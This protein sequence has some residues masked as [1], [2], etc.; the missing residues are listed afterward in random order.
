MIYHDCDDEISTDAIEKLL[1][2]FSKSPD[3]DATLFDLKVEDREG[4]LHDFR[5]FS[6]DEILEGGDCFWESLNNWGVHS[7]VCLKKD[8]FIKANSLYDEYNL[9]H[10]NNISN[11][12]VIGRLCW[13]FCRKVAKTDAIYIYKNNLKSTTK[14]VNQNFYSVLL[15]DLILHKILTSK[16]LMRNSY[17]VYMINTMRL[18]VDKY[19]IWRSQLVERDL[20]R[21]QLKK[22]FWFISHYW[23]VLPLKW[24]RKFIKLFFRIYLL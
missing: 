23:R 13:L 24:K 5:Y 6:A 20:W 15:N 17:Y 1:L 21:M 7:L 2:G 3:I 12:E 9:F 19:F 4:K 10:K 8:I 18:V 22:S 14:N 11:D 16:N